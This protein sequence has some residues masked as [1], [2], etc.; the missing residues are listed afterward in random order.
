[1]HGPAVLKED[2]KQDEMEAFM[3]IRMRHE[4]INKRFKEW[5]IFCQRYR[6]SE[7]CHGSVFRAI[8]V[9]V[10]LD[11]EDGKNVWNI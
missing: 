9:L 2:L 8:A 1:M 4:T 3:R 7:Y 10:Q 6:H 5:G 11:I